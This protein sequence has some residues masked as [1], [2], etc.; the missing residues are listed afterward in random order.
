METWSSRLVGLY[1]VP[2]IL[3]AAR[4]KAYRHAIQVQYNPVI[5]TGMLPRYDTTNIYSSQYID[6]AVDDI[7]AFVVILWT[8]AQRL[9]LSRMRFSVG[10]L[11][12]DG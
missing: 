7:A 1:Q 5:P 11:D 3:L 6:T 2:G 8:T 10:V 4:V 9:Y 12:V